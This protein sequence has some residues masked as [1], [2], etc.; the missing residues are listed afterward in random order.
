MRLKEEISKLLG[1]NLCWKLDKFVIFLIMVI[2]SFR[3]FIYEMSFLTW[4]IPFFFVLFYILP[5]KQKEITDIARV[6]GAISAGFI[7]LITVC[8]NPGFV[9]QFAEMGGLMYVILVDVVMFSI[10][11]LLFDASEEENTTRQKKRVFL[12]VVFIVSILLLA[13]FYYPYVKRN[14][15]GQI[16]RAEAINIAWKHSNVKFL[17]TPVFSDFVH[18]S[19]NGTYQRGDYN[20]LKLLPKENNYYLNSSSPYSAL[21]PPADGKEHYIWLITILDDNLV[22]PTAYYF[23]IDASNGEVVLSWRSD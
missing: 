7:P 2:V 8:I 1:P 15:T 6:A 22:W 13:S 9:W 21:Q 3:E 14:D 12:Y 11:F 18:V 23:G 4:V 20:T 10:I 5:K 19:A 16:T 17:T